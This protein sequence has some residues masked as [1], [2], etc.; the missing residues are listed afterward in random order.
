MSILPIQGHKLRAY[1]IGSVNLR[2]EST[3]IAIEKLIKVIFIDNIKS[4]TGNF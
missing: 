4:L 3:C 2:L 1:P